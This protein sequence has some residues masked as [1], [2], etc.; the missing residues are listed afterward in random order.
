MVKQLSAIVADMAAAGGQQAAGLD[1]INIAVAQLDQVTQRNASLVQEAAA[2][3]RAMERDADAM[4]AQVAYFRLAD[5]R[6]R[7]SAG[8]ASPVAAPASP[9]PTRLRRK[10]RAAAA[11][12]RPPAPADE[13]TFTDL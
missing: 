10:G 9:P 3:S 4:T 13:G 12:T 1:Q 2:A 6:A 5:G 11:V 7:P 8:A